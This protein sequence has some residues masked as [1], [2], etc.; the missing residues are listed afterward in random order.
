MPWLAML[1]LDFLEAVDLVFQIHCRCLIGNFASV[2]GLLFRL[3]CVS[4]RRLVCHTLVELDNIIRCDS[5]L[6]LIGHLS[7]V[8]RALRLC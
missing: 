3:S 7:S 8:L 2:A 5:F 4:M 6:V 1:P